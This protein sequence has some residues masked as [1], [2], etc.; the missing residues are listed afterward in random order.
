MAPTLDFLRL[1]EEGQ[2]PGRAGAGGRHGHADSLLRRLNGVLP[3]DE[4]LEVREEDVDPPVHSRDLGRHRR[5]RF[6]ADV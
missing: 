4:A 5:G 3:S 1:A 6:D 2:E